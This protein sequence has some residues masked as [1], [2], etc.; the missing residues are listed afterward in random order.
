[1][2]KRNRTWWMKAVFM[3]PGLLC[4]LALGVLFYGAMVYQL[5]DDG[6][7]S[8]AQR[9]EQA[10]TG[11]RLMLED[12]Q[13]LEEERLEERR[14]GQRCTVLVRRYQL[15]GG[16]QAEAVTAAPAA[17]IERLSEEKWTPQLTTGYTLAGMEAILAVR[18]EECML[19][20]RQGEMIYMLCMRGGEA[21]L[22]ALGASAGLD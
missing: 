19:C 10:R 14:G 6:T 20:A 13:L 1:M 16:A 5:A 22:G 2:K 9:T 17:Y 8:D 3:L 7:A 12:A 21:Q 11:G 4:A 18:G 15:E